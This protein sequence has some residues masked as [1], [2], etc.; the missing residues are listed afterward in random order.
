MVMNF[1][2]FLCSFAM[3][4]GNFLLAKQLAFA[5][6]MYRNLRTELANFI[7]LA[8]AHQPLGHVQTRE[9]IHQ[10]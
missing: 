8:L 1:Y 5:D 2:A 10:R 6:R 9:G 7:G 3:P 4:P